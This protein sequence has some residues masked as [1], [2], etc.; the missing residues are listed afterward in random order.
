MAQLKAHQRHVQRGAAASQAPQ[1]G[2]P[3]GSEDA[4]GEVERKLVVPGRNGGVVVKTQSRFP[5]AIAS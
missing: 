1:G 4:P 2:E 3:L 5:S